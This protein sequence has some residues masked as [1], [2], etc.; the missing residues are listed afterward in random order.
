MALLSDRADLCDGTC[1][2]EPKG[3]LLT[4]AAGGALLFVPVLWENDPLTTTEQAVLWNAARERLIRSESSGPAVSLVPSA[5]GA[6]GS[7]ALSFRF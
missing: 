3:P 4:M 2:V 7:L 5:R 6:G 1:N